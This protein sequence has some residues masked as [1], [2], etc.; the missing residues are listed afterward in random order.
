MAAF[1][2]NQ[3][4]ATNGSKVIHIQSGESIANIQNGDFLFLGSFLPC[5]IS[6]SYIGGA[7]EQYLELDVA[8]ENS[9][10]TEKAIVLP[11]TLELREVLQALKNANTLVNDN[12]KAMQDWQ[13][14]TGTVTFKHADGTISTIP[15]FKQLQA[16]VEATHPYP[17]AM[18]KVEF[19]ARRAA[20]NEKFAA[21]GFVH[22]GKHYGEENIN[23]GM[24]V[25]PTA[26]V[27]S[28]VQVLHLGRNDTAPSGTSKT[29]VPVITVAG[30]ITKLLGADRGYS[31][32]AWDR[33]SF[34]VKLPPA[35]GGTRTYDSATGIS[36]KHATPAIA[37][38][39]ET[40]T[41][42]VVTDR[43]DMWGFEAFLREINDADPF[44]YANG[45]IQSLATEINGVATVTD[46]ARPATYFAWYEG[47][48]TSIGK[49]VN[50]QTAT[51]A[52]RISIASDPENN[53]YFDDSTGK[54]YQ[55]CVRGRS[56]AGIGNGDWF[57]VDSTIKVLDSAHPNTRPQPQG[58]LD[59]SPL[60]AWNNGYQSFNGLQKATSDGDPAVFTIG[61]GV[62][63]I[64][65]VVDNQCYFLV[66]DPVNRLNQGAYHPSFNPSGAGLFGTGNPWY[67]NNAQLQDV[68]TRQDCFDFEG[69]VT[70]PGTVGSIANTFS[71]RPDG[72]YYDVIY[73]SGAGGVCRDMRY[74]AWGLTQED[75]AEAD[76]A[77]KSGEYRGSEALYRT[78]I[79][80]LTGVTTMAS[81]NSGVRLYQGYVSIL[82]MS[83]LN[84]N[85]ITY[86]I[87][88]KEVFSVLSERFGLTL[89]S[90]ALSVYYPE[91][92]GESPNVL[93][94]Y[95]TPE[96]TSIAD[97]YTHTEVIGDP[98]NILLCDDLKDGWVGSWNPKIP[99]GTSEINF[100]LNKPTTE[101]GVINTWR[102]T[103]NNGETWGEGSLGLNT[104]TN[105]FDGGTVN[106]V[107][108]VSVYSYKTKAKM[109][110]DSVNSEIYGSISNVN[111]LFTSMDSSNNRG[112]LLNFSLTGLTLT[113]APISTKIGLETLSL[114][115]MPIIPATGTLYGSNIAYGELRHPPLGLGSPSNN[116]PA[117]KALNYNVVQ[118]QQGFINYA[119]TELTYDGDWGDDSKLHIA[120]NQTT[121]LDTN[122]N[123]VK[124]GTARIVEPLG[125][126]KNDK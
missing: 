23:Q 97:E 124:V 63:A 100:K 18:R 78:K 119:Y 91:S 49:G 19:E 44:V 22:F 12:A 55:W 58:A 26:A 96:S 107:G 24:Y 21:S 32:G 66:C 112:R 34:I 108:N 46:N 17:Y 43:V 16:D 123:T 47:D 2:A 60:T 74:S 88:N 27:L 15:T 82:G 38:A 69:K 64:S 105:S 120:D 4:V 14:K 48:T 117:F 84:L 9:N 73:A 98:A 86:N 85:Y 95:P 65:S 39:S 103:S 68:Q 81:S 25:N 106:A 110:E 109:T 3:A 79:T 50:W 52:Q 121:M 125:W 31:V 35:E 115:S 59:A 11:T 37:F 116:S 7:G 89:G 76:L 42:K 90:N 101:T 113:H 41:N 93:V 29:D 102:Y 1:T 57:N 71:G 122:G 77:V 75:F 61:N 36:V 56:F 40:E 67:S 72:R 54:F 114:G 87:D 94:I 80:D 53:I 6:R 126:I 92:W 20:N 28:R 62:A 118:N 83:S 51:E 70:G 8:W 33:D 111:Y 5:T 30:V 104:V 99:D 45:L 13:T 10:Q